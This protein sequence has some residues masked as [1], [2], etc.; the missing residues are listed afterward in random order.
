[1]HETNL[2]RSFRRC[3][4][5]SVLENPENIEGIQKFIRDLHTLVLR[6]NSFSSWIVKIVQSAIDRV[7]SLDSDERELK[8]KLQ[9]CKTKL[10]NAQTYSHTFV[11]RVQSFF[12]LA[13][14]DRT[15][16]QDMKKAVRNGNKRSLRNYIT[17]IR[18]C[19]KQCQLRYEEFLE[20]YNEAKTLCETVGRECE[21]KKSEANRNKTLAK[22]V[23]GGVGALG[24]GAP[25]AAAAG[26]FTF[27]LG[28]VAIVSVTA[29]I[30]AGTAGV[31]GIT[32]HMAAQKF[33]KLEVTFKALC[34]DMDKLN[35]EVDDLGPSMIVIERMLVTTSDDTENIEGAG[36]VNDEDEDE[37]QQ[38][39]FDLFCGA[40][41]V[42]L[43]GIKSC[44]LTLTNPFPQDNF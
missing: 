26:F 44:R 4:L 16:A 37:F 34:Q 14:L 15:Q 11:D 43:D 30:G 32:A 23:G 20:K 2:V 27:G 17:R 36:R 12:R 41:H 9:K 28:T 10:R 1:M 35:T 24:L 33:N 42:L 19:L 22:V 5:E 6:L 25:I 13:D 40:L 8:R 31:A 39:E 38:P 3:Y 18:D 7:N 29:F 21:V